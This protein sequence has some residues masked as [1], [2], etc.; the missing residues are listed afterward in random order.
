MT[1]LVIYTDGGARGNPG[2]AAIGYVI[3]L[4]NSLQTKIYSFGEKIGIA[5]NNIAEYTA[6]LKA[7]QWLVLNKDKY[8]KITE[9]NFFLDSN[10]VVNQLNRKFKIKN[11]ELINLFYSIKTIEEKLKLTTLY[12]YVPREKNIYADFLVNQA[13]DS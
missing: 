6:V 12:N 3:Y 4:A 1:K 13:L 10:L 8:S 9:I 7:W 11:Q 5:T 2:F